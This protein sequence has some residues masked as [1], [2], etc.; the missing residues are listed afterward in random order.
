MR[1]PSTYEQWIAEQGVPVV[2]GYGVEDVMAVGRAPWPRL[3]ASGAVIKLEGMQGVTGMYVLDLPAGGTLNPERHLYEEIVYVLRGSGQGEVRGP[4]DEPVRFDWAEGSLF[5]VPLNAWHRFSNGSRDEPAVL[6][7]FTNA[8]LVLDLFHSHQFAFGDG[9]EFADRFDGR[10]DYY[11]LEERY[12]NEADKVRIWRTNLVRDV[13]TAV[14]D[15]HESKGAGV[16]LT[17][18][19]MADG[20]LVAHVADWPVGGYHKAHYH[21]AGATLLIVRGSGFSLMWPREAGMRPFEA[22]NGDKVV[23]VDWREGSVFSPPDNWFHQHFNTGDVAA[24]QLALRYGSRRY[25]VEFQDVRKGKGGPYQSIQK[26][27]TLIEYED[28]DPAIRPLF[29]SACAER[30]VQAAVM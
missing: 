30:G 4:G 25:F 10:S 21:G 26:G 5:A 28:E 2:G 9:Y 3:G 24:R 1:R 20:V 27:G 6:L 12:V 23:R 8:P 15:A 13:R 19:E 17:Q 7:C 16:R 11:E 18:F 29:E 22:G 14:I